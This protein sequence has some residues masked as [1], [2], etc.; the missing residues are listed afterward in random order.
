V[1]ADDCAD[2]SPSVASSGRRLTQSD[3]RLT[4]YWG[5]FIIYISSNQGGLLMRILSNLLFAIII[6]S[7]LAPAPAHA[8]LDGATV[9]IALQA[10]TGA[11]ASILLFGK[12]YWSKLKGFFKRSKTS[13]L[14]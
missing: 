2:R 14:D 5:C 12:I 9:S 3:D 6:F 8:Y 13:E 11:V 4:K 1:Q 10:V 7:A